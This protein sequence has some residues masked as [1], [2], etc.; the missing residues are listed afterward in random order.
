MP[1]SGVAGSSLP[2]DFPVAPVL[3]VDGPQSGSLQ[4][5]VVRVGGTPAVDTS[6][7]KCPC[8]EQ[9]RRRPSGMS[10]MHGG[11]GSLCGGGGRR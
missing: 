7:R 3:P 8:D 11:P 10:M 6:G 9:N 1:F 5:A 2:V 4:V